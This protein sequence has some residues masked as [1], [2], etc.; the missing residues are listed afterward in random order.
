[1][2]KMP[3]STNL[4]VFRVRL[5]NL[6]APTVYVGNMISPIAWMAGLEDFFQVGLCSLVFIVSMRMDVKANA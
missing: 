2:R 6:M 3:T 4:F 1:M 5:A